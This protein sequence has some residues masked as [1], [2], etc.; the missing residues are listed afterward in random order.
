MP[1]S[2][3]SR[4]GWKAA[5]LAKLC[6]RKCLGLFGRSNFP[7]QFGSEK[8]AAIPESRGPLLHPPAPAALAL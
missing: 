1:A 8:N 7:G 6:S 3:Y 2:R 5:K 4:D